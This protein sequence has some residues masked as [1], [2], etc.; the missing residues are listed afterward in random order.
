MSALA[1]EQAAWVARQ[2]AL[3]E[4]LELDL[5]D[6]LLELHAASTRQTGLRAAIIGAA[7]SQ[8]LGMRP[9]MDLDP[10]ALWEAAEALLMPGQTTLRHA[11]DG[12]GEGLKRDRGARR[13]QATTAPPKRSES[14]PSPSSDAKTAD[15]PGRPAG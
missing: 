7:T 1:D 3:A 5:S 9:L 8:G 15:A 11:I 14:P 2:K 6:W 10:E 4:A 13:F 12:Q